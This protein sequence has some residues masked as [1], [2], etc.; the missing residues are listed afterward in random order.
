VLK[1]EGTSKMQFITHSSFQGIGPS[2]RRRDPT[3]GSWEP[4]LLPQEWWYAPP[5]APR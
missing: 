5:P 4:G 3:G 2:A 1:A